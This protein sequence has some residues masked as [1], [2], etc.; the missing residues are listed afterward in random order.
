MSKLVARGY[1]TEG[2]ILALTY[3][4]SVPKVTDDIRM[5][6]DATMSGINDSLWDSKFILPSM[7]I[8]LKMVSSETHMFDLDV[9]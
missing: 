5:V 9:G 6:F 8:F 2:V 7:G 3:L 4:F 1:I